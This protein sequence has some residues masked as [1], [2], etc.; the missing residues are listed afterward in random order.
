MSSPTPITPF[1]TPISFVSPISDTT[2]RR[3]STTT[4]SSHH[5][6]TNPLRRLSTYLK[7]AVTLE[8][9]AQAGRRESI[10]SD[11]GAR[12]DAQDQALLARRRGSVGDFWR[13]WWRKMSWVGGKD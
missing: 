8:D 1:Y 11:Y 5:H 9:S 2:R 3:S 13:K 7:N 6:R 4:Q 12:E 10:I